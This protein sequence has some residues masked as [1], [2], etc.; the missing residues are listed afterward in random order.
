MQ[1]KQRDQRNRHYPTPGAHA[2]RRRPADSEQGAKYQEQFESPQGES[3]PKTISRLTP[4]NG[5]VAH[6]SRQLR[7][8]MEDEA[9]AA[10]LLDPNRAP[11]HL[12]ARPHGSI[13]HQC[14]IWCHRRDPKLSD[15]DIRLASPVLPHHHVDHH[16]L[17]IDATGTAELS[18]VIVEKTLE[19]PNRMPD[20][21]LEH[22]TLEAQEFTFPFVP[23]N[24]TAVVIARHS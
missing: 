18:E 9:P 10:F 1:R 24:R 3:D 5:N 15:D 6:A 8:L 12:T 23:L 21:I 13:S 22:Q 16:R 4:G 20:F 19:M 17:V 2:E 11:S 7:A 14:A